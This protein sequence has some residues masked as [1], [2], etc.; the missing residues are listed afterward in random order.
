MSTANPQEISSMHLGPKMEF[1][2]R[3]YQMSEE[4]NALDFERDRAMFKS[5]AMSERDFRNRSYARGVARYDRARDDATG[6][7]WPRQWNGGRNLQRHGI[8][9]VRNFPKR[10]RPQLHIVKSN[11]DDQGTQDPENPG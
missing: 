10:Q 5:G 6:P 3:V 9:D 8:F 7:P 4:E 2:L 1:I 11:D